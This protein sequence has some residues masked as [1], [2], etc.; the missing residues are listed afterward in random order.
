MT[1]GG[2]RTL[3]V[4]AVCDEVDRRLY[5][6][7][8]LRE[9]TQPELI[10][11]CGDLPAYYLDYLVSQ[12]DVPLFAVHG[13]QV[14][15]PPL[16][17]SA[18]FDGCGANWIGGRTKNVGG[19]LIAGFDGSLRYNSGAYQST[20]L[21]MH[22]AVRQLVPQ[23]LLNRLRY[24]RFLDV[25]ITHAPPRGIH[26]EPDTCHTGFEAFRWLVHRFQPRYHLHGHIHMYDRRK[27]TVT[28]VGATEVI[29][30]YPF[31]ELTLEL[32]ISS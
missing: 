4:L 28:R 8:A 16:E 24:G 1:A 26:D 9:R 7:S 29:N 19:L 27:P 22:A 14:A 31:R 10:F 18:G 15:P 21:E 12:F 6:N 17:G 3:K 11:G 2:V 13:F 25:L 20:Q 30:V 5:S 23:L 32:P